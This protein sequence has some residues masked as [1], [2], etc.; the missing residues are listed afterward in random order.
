MIKVGSLISLAEMENGRF[1]VIGKNGGGMA[2]VYFLKPMNPVIPFLAMKV[3]KNESQLDLFKSEAKIWSKVS[4]INQFASFVCYGIFEGKAY[5]ISEKYDA[6]LSKLKYSKL[7]DSEVIALITELVK[8]LHLGYQT[9]GLLHKDIKPSNIYISGMKPRIGDF[10]ISVLL[11]EELRRHPTNAIGNIN[12]DY[13]PIAGTIPFMAP[14]LFSENPIFSIQSDMYALGITLFNWISD[15]AFPLIENTKHFDLKKDLYFS[16]RPIDTLLYSIIKRSICLDPEGR[17]SSYMQIIRQ[18]DKNVTENDVIIA[19]QDIT[20]IINTI[21]T[22]RRQKLYRQAEILAQ[23]TLEKCP[24]HP[25]IINQLSLIYRET[26]REILGITVIDDL[27]ILPQYEKILYADAYFNL[28]LHYYSKR[29]INM[30]VSI[31]RKLEDD[32]ENNKLIYMHFFEVGL[33]YAITGNYEAGLKWLRLYYGT[34]HDHIIALYTHIYCS[35]MVGKIV[36]DIHYLSSTQT[37][38]NNFVTFVKDHIGNQNE[39]REIMTE[40]RKNLWEG[41]YVS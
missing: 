12:V 3:Y 27:D 33:F 9:C 2:D 31:I 36:E 6:D 28:S 38:N 40:V 16:K 34:K 10:G 17:Y 22:Q 4:F 20:S 37:A 30:F 14:E 32:F 35:Y 8:A 39:L 26:N 41:D 1:L 13:G 5:I 29:N 25:L 18:L 21:Q 15:G 24:N 11:E 7:K 23:S 19:A